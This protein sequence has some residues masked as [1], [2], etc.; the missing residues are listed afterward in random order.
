MAEARGLAAGAPV[1]CEACRVG[2]EG[3]SILPRM[4]ADERG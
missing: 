1:V 3:K 2:A 4:N